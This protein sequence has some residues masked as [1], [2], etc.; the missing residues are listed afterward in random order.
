MY[1]TIDSVKLLLTEGADIA[2]KNEQG[3]SAL[4]FAKRGNRPDAVEALGAAAARAPQR[5]STGKW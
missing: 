3:M 5:P 1:G 4:D 2:M